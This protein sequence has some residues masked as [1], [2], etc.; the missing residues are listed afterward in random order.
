MEVNQETRRLTNSVMTMSTVHYVVTASVGT[1]KNIM[2][3]VHLVVDTG[4]G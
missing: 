4:Y 3:S 2:H 1:N